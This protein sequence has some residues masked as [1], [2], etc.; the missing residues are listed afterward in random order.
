M[1]SLVL[2]GVRTP[3]VVDVEESC[4]RAGV[5]I[6]AA[7]S[8][9]GRP[10]LLDPRAAIEID[11]FAPVP[12]GPGALPCAF[13]PARRRALAALARERGL[14]LAEALVDPAA[15]VASSARL[16]PG[17]WVNAGAVLGALVLGGEGLLVNR[18]ATVGHHSVLGDY[19]SIGPGATLASNARVG[20]DV[21]IGAGA[22]ILPNVT[23]GDGAVV[24]AGAVVRKA[25]PAGTSVAGNPAR[26]FR[27]PPVAARR[28][29]EDE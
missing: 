8:V 7:V 14:E 20:S 22:V 19:V 25:V 24:A 2:F 21:V 1:D 17:S 9:S 5:R 29:E 28:W 26:P 16:S 10:R 13:S 6:A 23:L 11:A 15:V 18:G 3:L 12:G 4:L 27:A